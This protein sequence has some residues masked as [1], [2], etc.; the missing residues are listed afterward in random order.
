MGAHMVAS[1]CTGVPDLFSGESNFLDAF[2][3]KPQPER[4]AA[5]LGEHYEISVTNIKRFAVGSP[6]QAPLDA[7]LLLVKKHGLRASDVE[8]ITVALP[9]SESAGAR[10][11]NNRQ[12]PSVNM[13]YILSVALLDGTLSFHAAHATERMADPE[14]VRLKD[15]I[16]VVLDPAI[17]TTATARQAIVRFRTRGGVELS[18]HVVHVRGTAHNPMTDGEVEQKCLE[19]FEPVV[20][21]VRA[22]KL[23]EAVWNLDKLGDVRDLRPLLRAKE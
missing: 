2:S 20:G 11:V 21:R 8:A 19:L 9:A 7:L 16:S 6:I 12:M 14:V 4:L 13:Q 22:D 1:G 15:L 17:D 18:E 5:G 3:R 23:V 10:V